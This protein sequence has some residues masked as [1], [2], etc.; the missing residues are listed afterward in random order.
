MDQL[1]VP[2]VP[3]VHPSTN[4][5]EMLSAMVSEVSAEVFS[6]TKQ[7]VQIDLMFQADKGIRL[8]ICAPLSTQSQLIAY[9]MIAAVKKSFCGLHERYVACYIYFDETIEDCATFEQAD[10]QLQQWFTQLNTVHRHIKM[11]QCQ[12]LSAKAGN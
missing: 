5:I 7:G 10:K 3:E 12:T 9:S 4:Q 2:S 8:R 1:T 11:F 6:L